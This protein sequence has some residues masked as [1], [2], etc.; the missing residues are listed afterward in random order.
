[1]DTRTNRHA[2]DRSAEQRAYDD[3]A[4]S[5][6]DATDFRDDTRRALNAARAALRDAEHACAEAERAV[7]RADGEHRYTRAALQYA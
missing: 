7:H 1:M 5:L 6:A 2:D 3:A 4:Q